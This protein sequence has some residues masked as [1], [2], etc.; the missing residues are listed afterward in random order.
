MNR[1]HRAVKKTVCVTGIRGKSSVTRLITSILQHNGARVI[2]K[3]TG[4]K[5]V[6]LLPSGEEKHIKRRS[7]VGSV[8]EQVR[9][10]MKN[11]HALNTDLVV[12]E[13]MSITPEILD[14]E[15]NKILRAQIVVITRITP[16]HLDKMP[17]SR[18]ELLCM[19]A[20]FCPR[21][22]TVV[23]LLE[24]CTEEFK[25]IIR[26]KNCKLFSVSGE[27]FVALPPH[28]LEFPENVQ[29]ALKTCE[30]LGIEKSAAIECLDTISPDIGSLRAWF[31][32]NGVLAVNAFAS[33][34]PES[35]RRVFE[36]VKIA[37][38]IKDK[39]SGLLNL[40]SDRGERTLQWI[41]YLSQESMGFEKLFVIGGHAEIV[42]R[43]LKNI[44]VLSESD[45]KSLTEHISE[46]TK[47]IFGFGNIAG[48]GT[49]LVEY[50]QAVGQCLKSL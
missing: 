47:M 36:K 24:N 13:T 23:T 31:L 3:V 15:I 19:F 32:P 42:S 7:Y 39:I 2:G 40:R 6:L 28:Y 43:K 5:P 1:Y 50:W 22:S 30:L 33:N 27:E 14:I 34:D 16:D 4:S 38:G 11:A 12:C 9:V 49:A 37:S 20:K 25:Q 8:L 29:L 21:G 44:E 17:A 46:D 10:L 35:T 26:K 48:M 18:R 41:N 45:P